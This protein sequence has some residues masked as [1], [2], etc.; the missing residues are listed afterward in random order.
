MLQEIIPLIR[1][2]H[3]LAL[4]LTLVLS[5]ILRSRSALSE[6][7]RKK[8][9][10]LT[11]AVCALL[12][13]QDVLERYAQGDPSRRNLRMITSI[14][15]YSLRPAAVLGFLLVIWPTDKKLWYLWIPVILNAALYSTAPVFKELTFGFHDDNYA[16][17]RGPLGRTMFVVCI[18][19][20]ILILFMIHVR[21]RERRTGEM[22]TI[23]LCAAGCVGAMI[24]DVRTDGVTILTAVLVSS[25]TF[26]LFLRSQDTDHEPLT[27]LWNRMVFYED[28]RNLKTHINGVVSIDMNGLKQMNDELGHEAGDDALKTIGESLHRVMKRKVSA[29]R[30]GGDEFM[31][32]FFNC[33]EEE[34][35]QTMD[36]LQQEISAAGLSVAAGLAIRA[37]AGESLEEL[38]RISDQRMYESKSEYYRTHDRRERH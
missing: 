26:Y 23:Y 7:V 38:I 14:L 3:Y 25:I 5:S 29:Y 30:I 34:M 11:I 31:V 27:G 36:V 22:I 13:I 32:L 20:M 24:V 1:G 10:W 37:E 8:S 21:F 17:Y 16:F 28:C 2:E 18:L 6:K 33:R 12:V 15:G 19:Y 4:M 35:N 9:F